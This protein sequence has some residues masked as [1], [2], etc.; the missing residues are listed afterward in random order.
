MITAV[1]N[2]EVYVI[3][4]PYD[5]NLIFIIKSIPGRRWDPDNKY[6]T[7]PL[8]KLGFL[9]AQLRGSQYEEMLQVY[10]AEHINENAAIDATPQNNI[11]DIDLSKIP[12]IGRAHV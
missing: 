7:I 1:Q 9:I 12:Q 8:D 3:R 4:F 10:S 5:R 6:W 2:G 11:P